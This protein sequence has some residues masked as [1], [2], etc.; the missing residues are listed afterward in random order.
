[1]RKI[2]ELFLE[3]ERIWFYVGEEWKEAFF[4]EIL[5]RNARFRQIGWYR[6]EF[7]RWSKRWNVH[8]KK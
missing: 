7:E 8:I 6:N 2:D 3:H 5:P 4:E 1:M